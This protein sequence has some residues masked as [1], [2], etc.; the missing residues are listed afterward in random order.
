MVTTSPRFRG[1]RRCEDGDS[2]VRY[3]EAQFPAKYWANRCRWT[4][5]RGDLYHDG[6]TQRS[7]VGRRGA[8]QNDAILPMILVRFWWSLEL[9]LPWPEARL[10]QQCG[11]RLFVCLLRAHPRWLRCRLRCVL[12][13]PSTLRALLASASPSRRGLRKRFCCLENGEYLLRS[14]SSSASRE[15]EQPWFGTRSRSIPV[16]ARFYCGHGSGAM[17]NAL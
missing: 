6:P 3:R 2:A 8:R 17:G 13:Y 7:G 4:N 5:S 16:T 10:R 12:T 15:R 9:I 14:S 1:D 11:L